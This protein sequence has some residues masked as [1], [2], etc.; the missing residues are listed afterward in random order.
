MKKKFSFKMILA[1]VLSL[2]TVFALC[3]CGSKESEAAAAPADPTIKMT[4]D[5]F[6]A[7]AEAFGLDIPTMQPVKP[8]GASDYFVVGKFYNGKVQWQVDYCILI[9]EESAKLSFENTLAANMPK[10][11]ET[12]K[13]SD[14]AM[15]YE[16][17][18]G[19]QYGYMYC[20]GRSLI[21]LNVELRYKDDAKQFIAT[22]GL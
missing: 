7:K 2:L 19:N 20:Y 12:Q 14:G 8:F 11:G 17:T 6:K 18:E 21:L 4:V 16:C 22:L 9:N 13:L 10:G 15:V 5:T 1:I 3:A